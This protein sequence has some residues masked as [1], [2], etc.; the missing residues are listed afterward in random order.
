MGPQ[1]VTFTLID[2][3][4]AKQVVANAEK[5]LK[6][7]WAKLILLQY[8]GTSM[9]DQVDAFTSFQPALLTVLIELESFYNEV[10]ANERELISR[11]ATMPKIVTWCLAAL[12]GE[13]SRCFRAM[14]GEC[15]VPPPKAGFQRRN[16]ERTSVAPGIGFGEMRLSLA[17]KAAADLPAFF[18]RAGTSL[19]QGL[20]PW[21]TMTVSPACAKSPIMSN[22]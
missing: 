1:I 2:E 4:S 20:P 18:L 12:I 22:P 21:V 16:R 10:C 14:T 8:P 5:S 9:K 19:N 17:L 13:G 3:E 11:K 6:D 7:C 15:P